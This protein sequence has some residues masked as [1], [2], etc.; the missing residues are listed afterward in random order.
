MSTKKLNQKYEYGEIQRKDTISDD[1][2]PNELSI[3]ENEVLE[4]NESSV[5]DIPFEE[6]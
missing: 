6:E 2:S 5:D 1:F 3:S 4:L